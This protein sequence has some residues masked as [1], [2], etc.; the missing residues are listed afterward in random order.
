LLEAAVEQSFKKLTWTHHLLEYLK[1]PFL[2]KKNPK[3]IIFFWFIMTIISSGTFVFV[4]TQ[5]WNARD[6]LFIHSFEDWGIVSENYDVLT[7]SDSYFDN[8][9]FTKNIMTL[10]K[11]TTNILPSDNSSENPMIAYEVVIESLSS[12]AIVEIK[13]REAEFRDLVLRTVEE[14]N[15]DEL[16]APDGKQKL[17]EMTIERIN[18]IL[19]KSQI[20]RVYYS[21]FLLKY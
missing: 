13:D 19:T 18:S 21:H 6:K 9:N 4:K 3:K 12:D 20:R 8:P 17:S 10:S 16:T 1:Q 5:F 14:F 2:I 11:L 15:Y 7:E